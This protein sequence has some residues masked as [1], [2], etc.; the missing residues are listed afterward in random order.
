[1]MENQIG[2]SII[3]KEK[4]NLDHAFNL[5]KESYTKLIKNNSN[6]EEF[7]PKLQKLA[8]DVMHI[9]HS[10]NKYVISIKKREHLE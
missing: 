8:S 10:I 1:M 4:D 5:L 3:F 7:T 9:N 2:E 6:N